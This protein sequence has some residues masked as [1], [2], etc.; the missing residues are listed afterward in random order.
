MTLKGK[1]IIV[2]G[3]TS[4]IGLAVAQGAAMDGAQVLMASRDD[5]RITQA[6]A[7]LPANAEGRVLDLSN[8]AAIEAFFDATG[9]FDHLVYT[10]GESLKLSP[11]G[12]GDIASARHFFETRYWGAL[13]AARWGHR[14][15]RPG[16]SIVFTSGV[17][18]ARP[19]PGW[20]V[21]ASIC[22]AMEG[23]T[24][25]L[26]VELAPIRVNIVSPGVVKTPLWRE[27]PEEAREALYAAEARR[28]PVGRVADAQGVAEGYLYLMRQT[29]VTGQTL[30][31][32]GG[33]LLV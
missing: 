31:I 30:A 25:A 22:G 12:E 13:M 17:A 19:G 3:G 33:G 28:L 16:G 32:D 1:R 11:L 24:R 4:G 20:S 27:M 6:L 9:P 29:F 14:Q 5:A 23:L 18:G 26:A 7:T 2:L 8:A 21:A 10:A 15:I